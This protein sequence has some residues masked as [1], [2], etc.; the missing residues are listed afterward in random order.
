MDASLLALST[1][2][3]LLAPDDP[4]M[5]RTTAE[6]ERQLVHGGGVHRYALDVYFGGG[7]WVLLAG[8][9]GWHLVRCG[10]RED[11]LAALDWM[12]AQATPALDLPEQVATHVLFPDALRRMGGRCAARSRRRCSG[13]T[14]CT[15]SLPTSWVSSDARG[16][17]GAAR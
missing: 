17:A 5:V 2:F 12:A 13:R 11:A 14:R 7:E 4:L 10:R 1:P 15:W 3:G 8:F 6:I 16:G 9:L